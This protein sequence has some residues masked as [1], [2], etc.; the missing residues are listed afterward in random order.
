MRLSHVLSALIAVSTGA[1]LLFALIP[2]V[3]YSNAIAA[4]QGFFEWF[5]SSLSVEFGVLAWDM[6]VV[7]GIPVGLPIALATLV[8]CWI[9]NLPRRYAAAFVAAGALLALFVLIPMYS[10]EPQ[11]RPLLW[12]AS[13]LEYSILIG[14]AA[15][16]FAWRRRGTS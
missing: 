4:P 14:A 3:G 2:V 7:Y 10:G 6:L 1:F 8:V 13:A 5:R 9:S 15:G 16:A 12:W 11:T